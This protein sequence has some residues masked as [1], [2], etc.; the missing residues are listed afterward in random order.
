MKSSG[1]YFLCVTWYVSTNVLNAF[2]NLMRENVILEYL[3][4]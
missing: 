4:T 2:L 1:V 3:C